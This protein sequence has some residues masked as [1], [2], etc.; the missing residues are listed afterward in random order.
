MPKANHGQSMLSGLVD[1]DSDDQLVHPSAMPTPDSAAENKVPARRGRAKPKAAAPAKVT[2]T[3]APARR[4]SSR[5]DTRA[6]PAVTA[7]KGGRKALTDRTNQGETDTEDIDDLD[8]NEDVEMEDAEDAPVVAVK[9]TK[10]K[11]TRKAPAGRSKITQETA[12]NTS[13]VAE[14]RASN[15]SVLSVHA[16]KEKVASR[17]HAKSLPSPEKIIME[18]QVPVI[19]VDEE[20]TQ[21]SSRIALSAARRQSLS[22]GRQPSV[23]HRRAGSASDTERSDPALRRKLGEITKKYENL[24]VKYQDLREIGLKEAERNFERLRKQTEEKS[25]GKTILSLVY[26]ITN[27]RQRRIS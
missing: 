22:R 20:I 25:A 23:Q 19:D 8:Q 2:K 7:S 10:S 4:A 11:A 5:P 24:N 21:T 12:T 1:S 26:L 9:E 16:A 18:T 27:A 14:E 15:A 6:K 3:K 13:H 17:R